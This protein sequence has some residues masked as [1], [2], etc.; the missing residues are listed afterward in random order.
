MTKAD[1]LWKKISRPAVILAL[2]F[3][4]LVIIT[5]SGLAAE[6]IMLMVS[7]G[8]IFPTDA[9]YKNVYGETLFVPDRKSV[10]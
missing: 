1:K 3:L 8:Y 2:A 4:G 5:V 10:V 6:K 7:G 9:G